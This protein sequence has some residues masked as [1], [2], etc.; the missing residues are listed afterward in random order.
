MLN[1]DIGQICEEAM[2]QVFYCKV[3]VIKYLLQPE[4]DKPMIGIQ[5]KAYIK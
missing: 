2:Y 3:V 1:L 4:L 5:G